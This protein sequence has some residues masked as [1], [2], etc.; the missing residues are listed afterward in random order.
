MAQRTGI[1]LEDFHEYVSSLPPEL[2]R[3]L[4]TMRELDERAATLQDAVRAQCSAVLALPPLQFQRDDPEAVELVETMRRKIEAEQEHCLGLATEKVLLAQ[5][6]TELITSQIARLDEDLG[7]FEEDLKVEGKLSDF[8]FTPVSFEKKRPP[9]P[10]PQPTSA[11]KQDPA[12]EYDDRE[13]ERPRAPAITVRRKSQPSQPSPGVVNAANPG[14]GDPQDSFCICGGQS[15]GDMVQCDNEDCK[16]GV[17]FHY[18]CV[19]LNQA[20]RNKWYCPACRALQRRGLLD[21]AL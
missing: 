10:P 11:R 16:G 20:P 9:A 13:P 7:S 19:G 15:Y 8:A 2:Q 18:S 6:A 14:G 1:Y 4:S 12:P 3:L 5:Q 17:W 21:V